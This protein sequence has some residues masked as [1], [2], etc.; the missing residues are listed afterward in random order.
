MMKKK[1]RVI[2]CCL[3]SSCYAQPRKTKFDDVPTG[4]PI[5]SQPVEIKPEEKNSCSVVQDL[6]FENDPFLD[7]DREEDKESVFSPADDEKPIGVVSGLEDLLKSISVQALLAA[8]YLYEGCSDTY[9]YLQRVL[10]EKK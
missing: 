7:L 10:Y 6:L 5:F 8:L 1:I 2:I 3:I 9:Q 4:T